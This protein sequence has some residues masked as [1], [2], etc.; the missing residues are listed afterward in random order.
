MGTLGYKTLGENR[1]KYLGENRGKYKGQKSGF[2][3][4]RFLILKDPPWVEYINSY[5]SLEKTYFYALIQHT[6]FLPV[7][8]YLFLVGAKFGR[9]GRS[10]QSALLNPV[11]GSAYELLLLVEA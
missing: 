9:L 4:S 5:I 11:L 1:G 6:Y 7:D 8:L 10:L 2:F 3:Q